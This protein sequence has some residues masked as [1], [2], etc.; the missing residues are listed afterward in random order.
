MGLLFHHLLAIFIIISK[1]KR[2]G[3]SSVAHWSHKEYE[4]R[5]G[6]HSRNYFEWHLKSHWCNVEVCWC[7]SLQI[8][9]FASRGVRGNTGHLKPS[10]LTPWCWRNITLLKTPTWILQ[11]GMQGQHDPDR[12]EGST[13]KFWHLQIPQPHPMDMYIVYW[14]NNPSSL[15]SLLSVI[16]SIFHSGSCGPK[17]AQ[18]RMAA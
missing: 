2:F 5:D 13:A 14:L 3:I 6:I 15:S 18:C 1:K 9:H 7:S 17:Y 8:P 10:G 16:I 11:L 12:W 4:W